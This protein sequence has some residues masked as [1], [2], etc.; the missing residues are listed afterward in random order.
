MAQEKGLDLIEISPNAKPPV[1]RIMSHGKYQYEK[2]RKEKTTK[3]KQNRVEA[4]GIRI[5]P[6]IGQHDLEFKARQAEKFL[7]K[8]YKVKIEMILKG[9]EKWLL[10]AAQEKMNKFVEL[11]TT[12]IIFEQEIKKQPRGLLAVITKGVKK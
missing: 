10:E 2:S 7:E 8:G 1:C 4:K 6:R 9:R 5:S 11:I 12:E 3:T